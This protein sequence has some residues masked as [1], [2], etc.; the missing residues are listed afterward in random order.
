V[1]KVDSLAN[2][3]EYFVHHEDI[4]RAQPSWSPRVLGEEVEA[5]LWS[6]LRPAGKAL[7]RRA[8][9]GIVARSTATGSGVRLHPGTPEVTVEGLPS[10]IALYVFGRKAQAQVELLGDDASVARLHGTPLAF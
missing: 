10:E 5:T 6:M 1:P 7:T 9:V 3:L 4:R 8:E 2:T